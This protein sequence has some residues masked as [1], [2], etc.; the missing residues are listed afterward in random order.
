ML[1]FTGGK[2]FIATDGMG[3]E[4]EMRFIL[5][6]QS[7]PNSSIHASVWVGCRLLEKPR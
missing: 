6:Q 7:W 2:Y 5:K 1:I 3:V 4:E